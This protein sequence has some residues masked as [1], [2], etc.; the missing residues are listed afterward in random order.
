M[1][2]AVPLLLLW[3]FVACSSVTFT[4]TF[5][6]RVWFNLTKQ[7]SHEVIW[8]LLR[9]LSVGPPRPIHRQGKWFMM[10]II[11]IISYSIGT[12]PVGGTW[13]PQWAC[14]TSLLSEHLFWNFCI[15]FSSNSSTHL[16]CG[17]SL[18]LSPSPPVFV[19]RTLF[20]GSLSSI[21]FTRPIYLLY[22]SRVPV[23]MPP[24]T[25]QPKAYCTN[26]GL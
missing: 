23:T 18:L 10:M 4:F 5:R 20:T 1:S 16:N 13:P 12:I 3:A 22:C 17:L 15:T 11:I 21:L 9:G 14:V 7:K 2:R 19:Q 26:P 6:L 24:D 8:R 25:L